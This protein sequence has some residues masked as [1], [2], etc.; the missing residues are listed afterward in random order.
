MGVEQNISFANFPRQGNFLGKLTE[1]C[2][3]YDTSQTVA[4][5]VVRYD[6]EHPFRTIIQL[7]NGNYVLGTECQF[8]ILKDAT[9]H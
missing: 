7:A 2:F 6:V 9:D 5:I 4:G 8:R 3:D 1:V